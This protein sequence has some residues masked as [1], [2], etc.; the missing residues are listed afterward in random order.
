MS[1]RCPQGHGSSVQ[2]IGALLDTGTSTSMARSQF[3]GLAFDLHGHVGFGAAG[4]TTQT[5]TTTA[6][7][8]RFRLPAR[9]E[10]S[11]GCAFFMFWIAGF[12]VF[13]WNVSLDDAGWGLT[14]T[15]LALP[16][17]VALCISWMMKKDALP[18][19][20]A[21]D[22]AARDLRAGWYCHTDGA[23]F[24]AGSRVISSP[25]DFVHACFQ[26][27]RDAD[28]K[29]GAEQQEQRA[30]QVADQQVWLAEQAAKRSTKKALAKAARIARRAS[31]H[32][33]RAL[34]RADKDDAATV[35]RGLRDAASDSGRGPSP[36]SIRKSDGNPRGAKGVGVR[37][38]Q[39]VHPQRPIGVAS[40]RNRRVP[41]VGKSNRQR[42]VAGRGGSTPSLNEE[43]PHD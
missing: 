26:A 32:E 25:E 22:A 14:S 6:L 20:A 8:N 21:W 11:A 38:P 35:A 24:S 39:E 33:S 18:K 43:P 12:V 4:G 37:G 17:C 42:R 40:A 28:A 19:Q 16:A 29:R 23:A 36:R 1:M 7:A 15:A 27:V 13:V 2:Q 9:P 5:T 10:S 31:R 41:V 34:A 30:L 3:Q